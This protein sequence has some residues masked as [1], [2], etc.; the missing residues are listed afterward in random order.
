MRQARKVLEKDTA[1]AFAY[2]FGSVARG[3]TTPGSDVDVAIYLDA[4]RDVDFFDKRL[5]LMEEFTRALERG[6]DVVILNTA[7][8]VLRYAIIQEGR[9]IYT[10]SARKKL[11][12]ELKVTN[13]YMDYQPVLKRYHR[14][15]RAR[16]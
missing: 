7:P 8:P 13:E 9:P 12:F 6:A 14:R 2:L 4:G 10:R 11:D 16:L 3:D 1:V 5:A 15:L